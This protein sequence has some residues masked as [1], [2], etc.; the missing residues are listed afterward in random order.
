VAGVIYRKMKKKLERPLRPGTEPSEKHLSARGLALD[1]HADRVDLKQDLV[2]VRW[3][4]PPPRE[5]TA[6]LK[7]YGFKCL[8]GHSGYKKLLGGGNWW[9]YDCS[10]PQGP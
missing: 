8:C 3:S 5:T 1:C 6:R 2:V 10:E 4:I 7:T 9:Y